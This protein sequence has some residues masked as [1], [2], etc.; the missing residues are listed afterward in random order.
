MTTA[1]TAHGALEGRT[2]DRRALRLRMATTPGVLRIARFLLLA[3][4]VGC[5][6]S[7]VLMLK[8][9]QDAAR[10][11]QLNAAP[12]LDD[13]EQLYVDL[14]DA[15]A[16]ATRAFLQGGLEDA[17]T[18]AQ[19][20][21]DLALADSRITT[22]G[23]ELGRDDSARQAAEAVGRG[24]PLYAD[25]VASA[26]ANKR[27]GYPVGAAYLRQASAQLHNEL[28]PS[29]TTTVREASRRLERDYAR[30]IA[31]PVAATAIAFTAILLAGLVAIQAFLL[32][33]TNRILNVALVS[34][35][36]VTLLAL[37][38]VAAFTVHAQRSLTK[39]ARDGSDPLQVLVS[40]RILTLH[41]QSASTASVIDREPNE[42][43]L[44]FAARLGNGGVLSEVELLDER[45][46]DGNYTSR[47][48]GD[49]F[50]QYRAVLRAVQAAL[51]RRDFRSAERLALTEQQER[52]QAFDAV[53]AADIERSHDRL[54]DA[55]AAAR[56]GYLL[57]VIVSILSTLA[58]AFLIVFG[59]HQRIAEYR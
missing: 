20:E 10:D 25:R 48:R 9:R 56:D 18:H 27:L 49:A 43:A 21:R 26:R 14:S 23:S 36:L 16:T 13:A 55:A 46:P 35:V 44:T 2:L 12:L 47:R 42:D 32:R 34:S 31:T 6:V 17:A 28:L 51:A 4:V 57:I 29:A 33:R 54:N 19:Y 45:L 5:A 50:A 24:L 3:A 59:L 37:S 7:G 52:A 53:L 39:A 15:D 11:V 41:A 38:G 30:G 40:T 1:V 58:V 22:I 8:T